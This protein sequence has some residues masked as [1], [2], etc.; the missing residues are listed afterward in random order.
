LLAIQNLRR[1]RRRALLAVERFAEPLLHQP[2]ANVLDGLGAAPKRLG[3]ASIGPSW[4]IG[5]GLE[6]DLG[7]FDLLAAAAELLDDLLQFFAFLIVQPNNI[8]LLHGTPPC[9]PQH[10]Q[11]LNPSQS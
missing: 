2:L 1:R 3:N 10:G 7:S 6:K 5:I 8:L 9:S 11:N 4:P